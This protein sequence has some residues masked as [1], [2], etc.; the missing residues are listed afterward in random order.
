MGLGN[1]L[2]D[3][4]LKD[5]TD[6]YVKE[7]FFRIDKFFK[8]TPFFRT[9]MKFF[10]I[11]FAKAYT[12]TTLAHGLGFK[13]TDLIQTFLT[14]PGSLTWNYDLF[15]STNLV[16]STTGACKVRAFIGAYREEI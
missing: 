15:D 14:G 13:P 16:V 2:P 12:N 6:P 9:E 11:T 1:Q 4:I 7:N 8:K 5:L 10:E 3:I